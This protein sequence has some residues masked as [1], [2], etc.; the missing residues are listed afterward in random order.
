ML[1]ASLLDTNEPEAYVSKVGES[2]MGQNVF[3]LTFQRL[4]VLGEHQS[5]DALDMT[6]AGAPCFILM[7]EPQV[8]GSGEAT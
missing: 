2:I 4:S 6:R 7:S 1:L 3:H 8:V 5:I